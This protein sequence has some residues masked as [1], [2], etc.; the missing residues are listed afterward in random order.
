M[1]SI[2]FV[3]SERQ[4][5]IMNDFSLY[6]VSSRVRIDG[7]DF[8]YIFFFFFNTE[9]MHGVLNIVCFNRV[10]NNRFYIA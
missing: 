5:K 4:T 3:L 1:T 8:S 10:G 9:Q 6:I 7:P 2:V